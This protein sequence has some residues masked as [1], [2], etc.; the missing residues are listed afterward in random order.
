VGE[1]DCALG[2]PTLELL[3]RAGVTKHKGCA[4]KAAELL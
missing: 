2:G 3:G 4:V 1:C